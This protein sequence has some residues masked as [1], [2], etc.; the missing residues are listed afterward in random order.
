MCSMIRIYWNA[1]LL[2]QYERMYAARR[3]L[4]VYRMR[5]IEAREREKQT[6]NYTNPN[7]E[8]TVERLEEIPLVLP[9]PHE[10]RS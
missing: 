5:K 7:E 1:E 10:Q 9:L 8:A 6:E 3:M 4:V 2:V